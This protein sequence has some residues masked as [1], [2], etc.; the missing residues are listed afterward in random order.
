MNRPLSRLIAIKVECSK[1]PAAEIA[2]S[3][4][5]F[6]PRFQTHRLEYAA[7]KPRVESGFG[8]R[9]AARPRII[10]KPLNIPVTEKPPVSIDGENITY[11]G[12][13]KLGRQLVISPDGSAKISPSNMISPLNENLRDE[14]SPTGFRI[15][16]DG[17]GIGSY[18]ANLPP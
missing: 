6:I 10:I 7:E 9:E 18:T 16:E 12:E 13:V 14:A 15:F 8:L 2:I 1:S 5:T 11:D 3:T 4:E 17:Y